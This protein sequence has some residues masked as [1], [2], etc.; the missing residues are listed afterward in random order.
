MHLL[1]DAPSSHP[2]VSAGT[3]HAASPGAPE[4]LRA[5]KGPAG[6]QHAAVFA[7]PRRPGNGNGGARYGPRTRVIRGSYGGLGFFA[8]PHPAP[9]PGLA[10]SPGSFNPGRCFEGFGPAMRGGE[11]PAGG[12]PRK[13]RCRRPR[14]PPWVPKHDGPRAPPRGRA[15]P[16]SDLSHFAARASE[17]D[18]KG[19]KRLGRASTSEPRHAAGCGVRLLVP[20]RPR[21]SPGATEGRYECPPSRFGSTLR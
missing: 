3:G 20:A 7:R 10:G 11:G 16:P 21:P 15:R 19:E 13:R 6:V 4:A 2:R 17:V 9:A 8:Q 18:G 14:P 1:W 5:V 12:I